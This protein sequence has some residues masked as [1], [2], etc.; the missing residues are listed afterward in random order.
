LGIAVW[1]FFFHH[2]RS[3]GFSIIKL[4]FLALGV[5][6][7]F[8]LVVFAFAT[9]D[10]FHSP[11]LIF[12]FFLCE[13]ASEASFGVDSGGRCGLLRAL[14]IHI[15]LLL[16]WVGASRS[17]F[18]CVEGKNPRETAEL[19]KSTN[20]HRRFLVVVLEGLRRGGAGIIVRK[21][22]RNCNCDNRGS[23]SGEATRRDRVA[24][25]GARLDRGASPASIHPMIMNRRRR[26]AA[27][28]AG[29]AASG[30]RSTA[31][32]GAVTRNSGNCQGGSGPVRGA[33]VPR[34]P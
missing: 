6:W 8:T 19:M 9:A 4:G 10:A 18:R 13:W 23:S 22:P 28:R 7:L 29:R 21:V 2:V 33:N 34:P 25:P 12:A 24:K 15:K 3:L 31:A 27:S 16:F 14:S 1:L 11:F 26:L 20:T 17:L 5:F 32:A 30:V